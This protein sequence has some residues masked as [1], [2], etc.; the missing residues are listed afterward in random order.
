MS[1]TLFTVTQTVSPLCQVPAAGVIVRI[2]SS[3]KDTHLES[4]VNGSPF[5]VMEKSMLDSSIG[6]MTGWMN[7][8]IYWSSQAV[9]ESGCGMTISS[10]G[11][12]SIT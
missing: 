3:W 6:A 4:T 1:S 5:T 10:V 7:S 12:A 11:P 9:M 8:S 2:E